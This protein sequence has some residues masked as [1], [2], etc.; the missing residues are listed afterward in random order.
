MGIVHTFDLTT[1]LDL[2]EYSVEL[3][4]NCYCIQTSFWSRHD[5]KSLGFTTERHLNS[6]LVQYTFYKRKFEARDFPAGS[7][8]QN[9]S[10][11]PGLLSLPI[12]LYDLW[13]KI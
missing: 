5:M 2:Q 9:E 13:K 4:Y 6:C 8:F 12:I 10:K 11:I 3:L 7:E 1:N